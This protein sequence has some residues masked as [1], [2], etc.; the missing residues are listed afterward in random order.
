MLF[1]FAWRNIWRNKRRTLITAASVFTAVILALLMRSLQLGAYQRMID[2][3]VSYYTGHIQVHA[4]GYSDEKTLEYSFVPNDSIIDVIKEH[5]DIVS[6]V[7]RL[8]SFALVSAADLTQGSLVVG[9]DP[10]AEDGL[11]NLAG[12]IVEGTYLASDDDGVI[13]S[14]GLAKKLEAH[15]NDTIV[16]L[17]QGY[18]GATA[19]GK[20]PIRGV[21]HFSAPSLNNG[22]VYLTIP[23][24]QYL[25]ST[26]DRLTSIAIRISPK[27]DAT[28]VAAALRHTTEDMPFE[29]LDWKDM[30]PEMVELIEVDNAGGVIIISILYM[31]IGFGI[32]GTIL[33]MLAERQHEFGIL[34][35]VGMKRIK[36][37]TVVLLEILMIAF[38][39]TIAGILVGIPII[40]YF[41]A[42]PIKVTGDMAKAYES[43]GMEAIFPFSNDIGLFLTQAAIVFFMSLVLSVYPW[44]RILR[45][46]A[47][48][49]LKQ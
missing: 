9:I 15:T 26:G 20:Y 40:G 6:W 4:D 27:A 38:L 16:L 32:F 14:E 45:L 23:N 35:A 28:A 46:K 49:A 7:P 31:I 17:G 13:I 18:H 42:N 11:T 22:M 3:V 33:M 36:L 37:A 48:E 39:G 8:E 19:A 25:Y 5:P 30:L 34:V 44:F 29:I 24:A 2:N 10:A 41:H 47:I 21:A 1:V 12:K 43:F